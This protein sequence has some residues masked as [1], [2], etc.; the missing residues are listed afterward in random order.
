MYRAYWGMEFNPF[1]K[2]ITEKQFY[3][4]NDFKEMAK[5]PEYLRNVRGIGLRCKRRRYPQ[6]QCPAAPCVDY[7]V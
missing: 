3:K 6:A 7:R 5:R 1:D 4:N 2:E